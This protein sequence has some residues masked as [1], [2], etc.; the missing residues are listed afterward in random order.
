[1]LCSATLVDEE[2]EALGASEGALGK[3]LGDAPLAVRT[4]EAV[5]DA[6]ALP[7]DGRGGRAPAL[8]MTEPA[9]AARTASQ[10]YG[11]LRAVITPEPCEIALRPFPTAA[12]RQ[13]AA[14]GAASTGDERCRRAPPPPPPPPP[15]AAAAAA[16]APAPAAAAAHQK[17]PKAFFGA[18]PPPCAATY[19]RA[20][21]APGPNAFS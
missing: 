11:R 14:A 9:A 16:A 18:P 17:S 20:R 6:L 7:S 13:P 19:P 8:R 1:M 15:R 5:R 12:A 4:A 2:P 21:A 10:P 3:P